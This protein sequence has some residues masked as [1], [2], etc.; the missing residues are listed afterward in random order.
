VNR[1]EFESLIESCNYD[2]LIGKYES[3]WLECKGEVY[4]L[5]EAE[6]EKGKREL[7]KDI[8]SFAN[9]A[10]GGYILLGAKTE[11]N[12]SHHADTIVELKPFS[13]NILNA[14]QYHSIIKEWIYPVP[15]FSV[16]WLPYKDDKGIALI[17]IP[18]QPESSKPYLITKIVD[19]SGKKTEFIFGY[20]ERRRANSEPKKFNEIHQLIRDGIFYANNITSRLDEIAN[21]ISQSQ[22]KPVSEGK[23][24]AK[25]ITPEPNKNNLAL[26]IITSSEQGEDKT[27]QQQ[28]MKKKSDVEIW[29]RIGDAIGASELSKHRTLILTAFISESIDMPSWVDSQSS[30]VKA[31]ESPPELRYSGWDLQISGPRHKIIRG[32]VRRAVE[33]E[34][35]ILDLYRDGTV[36]FAVTAESDF[37]AWG[38]KSNDLKIN[39]LSLIETVYN[40]VS[41]YRII[42]EN[43]NITASNIEFRI[44]L[45]NMHLNGQK[46]F[47]VPYGL[48]AFSAHEEYPA[49][50]DTWNKTLTVLANSFDVGSIAYRIVQEIYLW[51][52]IEADKIPYTTETAGHKIIDSIQITNVKG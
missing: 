42:L 27:V 22:L 6:K 46:T 14:E 52:G 18:S 43:S 19:A 7:A 5:T 48:G 30:L 25:E 39:P 9:V 1:T 33:R 28:P 38:T 29:Q 41:F 2:S 47:M 44:D 51:F 36:V 17:T 32:E 31:F 20:A 13:Q 35:K 10:D 40:F 37:L 15:N 4:I 11:K 45:Y 26:N 34:Q 50:T 3:E 16:K 21:L 24:P 23:L 49:P 8:S 12:S